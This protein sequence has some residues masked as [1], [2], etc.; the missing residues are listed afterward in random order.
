VRAQIQQKLG[1]SADALASL[2]EAESLAPDYAP[3]W[4]VRG[5]ILWA[6]QRWDEAHQAYDQYLK[7]DPDSARAEQIRQRLAE[8]H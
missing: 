1:R 3:I 2:A 5:G 4:D 7:L 6:A 8:P